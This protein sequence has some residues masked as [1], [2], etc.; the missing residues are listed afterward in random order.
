MGLRVEHQQID[1]EGFNS[2]KH[3]PINASLSALWYAT[4]DMLISLA[5]TRAQRA[6]DIQELFSNG[7]HFATQSYE[8]GDKDLKLETSYNLELGF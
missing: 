5:F 1:T 8:L 3:T 4:D 7:V 6:P 2:T